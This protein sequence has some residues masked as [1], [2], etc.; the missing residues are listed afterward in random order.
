MWKNDIDGTTFESDNHKLSNVVYSITSRL[1]DIDTYLK[2][3][4]EELYEQKRIML[5]MDNKRVDEIE[6][7]SKKELESIEKFVYEEFRRI[8]DNLKKTQEKYKN[9]NS[10]LYTEVTT[11]KKDKAEIQLKIKELMGRMTNIKEVIGY[12]QNEFKK[13]DSYNYK[14]KY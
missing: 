4:R 7:A 8:I 14:K 5:E 2:Q 13:L 6:D 3:A 9:E 12:S 1:V 10:K 11:L